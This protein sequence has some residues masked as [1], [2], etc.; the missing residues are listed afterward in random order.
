MTSPN[1]SPFGPQGLSMAESITTD[2]PQSL[3]EDAPIPT[4]SSP[5][6]AS[7]SEDSASIKKMLPY[8]ATVG[9]C[10]IQMAW[11]VQIGYT[12]AVMRELGMPRSLLGLA[13]LAGPMTGILVQP[14]VGVMSDCCTSPLGRRRP[15]I[16]L[17]A[18]FT[19]IGLL[20]F[21]NSRELGRLF[22]D[23]DT[24]TTAGL[25]LSVIFFWV[26]DASLNIAQGPQ[27]ALLTDNVHKSQLAKGNALFSAHNGVGKML[28]YGFG[29]VCLNETLALQWL[30]TEVQALYFTAALVLVITVGTTAIS[31]NEEPWERPSDALSGPKCMNVFSE[32]KRGMRT[33]PPSF[34]TTFCVQCCVYAGWFAVFIW[35]SLWVGEDVFGGD[36]REDV[37]TEP[38]C[39]VLNRFEE[40]VQLANR[41][42]FNMSILSMV[43]ATFLPKLCRKWGVRHVWCLHIVLM[44][45][46]LSSTRYVKVGASGPALAILSLLGFP[47]AATY[48][49]P[50]S[51]VTAS[52]SSEE[53]SG[54]RALFS[55]IFNLAQ[56]F[57]EIFV[58]LVGAPLVERTGHNYTALS[59]S[60]LFVWLGSYLCLSVTEPPA[61]F[62]RGAEDSVP[63]GEASPPPSYPDGLGVS[64]GAGATQIAMV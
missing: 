54:S 32:V 17:G 20:G 13:W 16:L 7:A 53:Y 35:G 18:L 26:L 28:G 59:L 24:N 57:P 9:F 2:E 21:S 5:P 22:G 56:C 48:A 31:V 55:T 42:F 43:W 40:G 34:W 45:V 29:S 47:L 61:L 30:D 11:A 63:G 1:S 51:I 49:L 39:S 3:D 38:S 12:S 46:L 41:G 27:R 62:N 19:V 33:A 64:A 23:T 10:G 58:A 15:F 8:F 14:V 4:S 60:S 36:A 6:P 52:V 50:W 44:G 25:W 37:G